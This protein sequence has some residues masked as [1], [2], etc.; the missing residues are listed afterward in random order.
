MA[1]PAAEA[2]KVKELAQW[3]VRDLQVD[4]PE[5]FLN[6]LGRIDTMTRGET[7]YGLLDRAWRMMH[8]SRI[9]SSMSSLAG[10]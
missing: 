3:A 8:R 5:G 10:P 6:L 1:D 9:R 4:G 7:R 2:A